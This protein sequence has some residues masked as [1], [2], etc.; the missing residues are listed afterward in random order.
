M[1]GVTTMTNPFEEDIKT[2][3]WEAAVKKL[4]GMTENGELQW[5]PNDSLRRLR[6]DVELVGDA[7]VATVDGKQ[8]AIYEYRYQ[9]FTDTDRWVLDSGLRIEFITPKL[10]CEWTWPATRSR[11]LLLETIRYGVSQ[12]NQFLE[13]FLTQ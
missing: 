4:I 1:N 10:E 13:R 5:A 2:D 7:Y 12:A 8:V 3:R 6:Q 11:Y 9:C